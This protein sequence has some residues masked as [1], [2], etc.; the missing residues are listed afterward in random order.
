MQLHSDTTKFFSK[1]LNFHN[2]SLE[3]VKWS[4]DGKYLGA[5]FK[6]KSVKIGQLESTGNIRVVHTVPCTHSARSVT[7]NPLDDQRFAIAGLDK[8]IEL[9]DVRAPKATGKILAPG[10][11]ISVSW[12]ANGHYTL[13]LT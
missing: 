10:T 4:G 8:F 13:I 6:D 12:S 5:A 2:K 11:N 9:W 7:W 1:D 3:A